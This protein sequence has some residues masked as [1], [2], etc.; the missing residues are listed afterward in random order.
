MRRAPALLALA[1]ALAT[2]AHLR[3]DEIFKW[4]DR[5][6]KVHFSNRAPQDATEHEKREMPSTVEPGEG[7]ESTL[8]RKQGAEKLVGAADR[9]INSLQAQII[10][11]RRER[12]RIEPELRDTQAAIVR[13][14]QANPPAEADLRVREAAQLRRIGEIDA[15]IAQAEAQI[16]KLRV[17]KAAGN[18][19]TE[20]ASPGQFQ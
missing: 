4:T 16:D 20:E 13:A 11:Q 3:A 17:M 10:R 8:E 12:T 7:W 19:S 1:I 15:A 9:A 18:A 2:A 6:G 5:D 14:R